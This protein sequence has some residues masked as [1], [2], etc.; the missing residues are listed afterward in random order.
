M[1]AS[2]YVPIFFKNRLHL[3]GRP[4]MSTSSSLAAP[5]NRRGPRPSHQSSTGCSSTIAAA[6]LASTF[7]AHQNSR[8]C[9]ARRSRNVIDHHATS[10]ANGSL[11]TSIKLT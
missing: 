5:A 8:R 9:R 1:A 4:Q 6:F 7:V 2:D 10:L 3:A 11:R